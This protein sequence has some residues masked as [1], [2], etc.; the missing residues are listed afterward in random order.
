[1]NRIFFIASFLLPYELWFS[2]PDA[3]KECT[4]LAK[5]MRIAANGYLAGTKGPGAS[6][7]SETLK[8]THDI[9]SSRAS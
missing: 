5:R 4:R 7:R 9:S 8:T 2:F 3:I 1:M 6:G